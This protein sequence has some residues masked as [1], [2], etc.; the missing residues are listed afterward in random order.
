MCKVY[1]VKVNKNYMETQKQARLE[2]IKSKLQRGDRSELARKLGVSR[3][4]VSKVTHGHNT[5]ER[6]L[7]AAEALIAEREKELQTN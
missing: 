2:L 7:S 6:V 5:S 4:F 3:V 1:D